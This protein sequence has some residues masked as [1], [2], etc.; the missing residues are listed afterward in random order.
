MSFLAA[1]HPW[2]WLGSPV[3][4]PSHVTEGWSHWRGS[5]SDIHRGVDIRAPIGN[6]AYSVASGE[7]IV[8]DYGNPTAGNW[9]AVRHSGGLVSRYIHL[10]RID[11]AKGQKVSKGQLV[12]LTGDTAAPGKPHLHFDLHVPVDKIGLHDSLFGRPKEG[13]VQ[14]SWG[15]KVPV[16]SM[17]AIDSYSDKAREN[18]R[19]S[20]VSI[21][22]I[23][24]TLL[25]VALLGGGGVYAWRRWKR[26]KRL[27][28]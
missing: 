27:G 5:R 8:A 2:G 10:S 19:A 7:V 18:A 28:A 1:F 14:G 17:I 26:R 25:T 11:V 21:K 22:T 16:E 20:G 9:I 23:A 6:P 13:Y 3:K 4:R 15:Y 12:G 24:G